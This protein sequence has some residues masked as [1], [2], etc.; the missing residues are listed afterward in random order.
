MLSSNLYKILGDILTFSVFIGSNC[1]RFDKKLKLLSYDENVQKTV[2]LKFYLL[3][4]FVFLKLCIVFWLRK[5]QDI[6]EYQL[7]LA[8]F[9][10]TVLAVT[11]YGIPAYFEKDTNQCLN[12]ALMLFR[13]I[14][15]KFYLMIYIFFNVHTVILNCITLLLLLL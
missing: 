2:K 3:L 1:R 13:H 14:H 8:F 4:V 6:N 11:V 5:Q 15:S 12:G 10:L 7:T 9:L